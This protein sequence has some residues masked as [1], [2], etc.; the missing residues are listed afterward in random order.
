MGEEATEKVS[1]DITNYTAGI[2]AAKQLIGLIK[3]GKVTFDK[4]KEMDFNDQVESVKANEG[5][6]SMAQG[7]TSWA[8]ALS[9]KEKALTNNG[10]LLYAGFTNANARAL[11]KKDDDIITTERKSIRSERNTMNKKTEKNIGK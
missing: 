11:E 8:K 10:D 2:I 6:K 7:K 3:N 4:L 9:L 1:Q 5:F